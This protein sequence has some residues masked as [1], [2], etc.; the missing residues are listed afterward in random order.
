MRAGLQVKQWI[1]VALGAMLVHVTAASAQ[2]VDIPLGTPE[3]FSVSAV[4]PAGNGRYCISGR[5]Y[6]DS[7]PSWSGMAVMVDANSRR[8]LWRTPIPFTH[9]YAGNSA[10]ACGAAGQSVYVVSV[11]NTQSSE[12]LNQKS[13]VLNRL[14][15]AGKLEKQQTIRAGFDEWFYLFDVNPAGITVAGSTSEKSAQGGPFGNYI[16]QFNTDLTQT[17]MKQLPSGAFGANSTASFDGKHL[18]VAGQ[19]LPNPGAGHDGYA[20]SK[21]DFDKSRYLWST[22]TLPSVTLATSALV[23]QD[24]NVVAV[25]SAPTGVLT[26]TMLDRLGKI[27]STFTAKSAEFCKLKA[28]SLDGHT[29]K[30][31]G[32]ACKG[33][34]AT[35]LLSVDL[36]LHTVSTAHAFKSQ[37]QASAI[38]AGNWIGVTKSHGHG[39]AF[40]RGSE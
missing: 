8:V 4:T 33:D 10:L 17:G 24:G 3:G 9:G 35:Q 19:F 6:D 25:A 1:R 40:Q 26:I 27:A 12:S 38:D 5:V 23:T 22:Y 20:V 14:S 21:I 2:T 28:A 15:A 7:G 36:T 29:L 13:V 39:P 31:F 16:A 32:D 18:L 30:L 34:N 11:E 37:L